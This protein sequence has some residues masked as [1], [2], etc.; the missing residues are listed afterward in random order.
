MLAHTDLTGTGTVLPDR[1]PFAELTSR[2]PSPAY[3]TAVPRASSNQALA[4]VLQF[5][6]TTIGRL[7]GNRHFPTTKTWAPSSE[8]GRL[9]AARAR[10]RLAC[11]YWAGR[12]G[13]E[14][15]WRFAKSARRS[16][17]SPTEPMGRPLLNGYPPVRRS[18]MLLATSSHTA[19]KSNNSCLPKTF[20]VFPQVADTSMPLAEGN[21]PNPCLPL[22]AEDLS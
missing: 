14:L 2:L 13:G 3:L 10:R 8:A 9:G 12:V 4:T 5:D 16:S 1:Y 21:H 22:R 17:R 11:R 19:A 15:A 20:S 6:A 18:S 7:L